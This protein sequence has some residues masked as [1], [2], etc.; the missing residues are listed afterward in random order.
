MSRKSVIL[1]VLLV[2]LAV[3]AAAGTAPAAPAPHQT[4]FVEAVV[5]WVKGLFPG[6]PAHGKIMPACGSGAN[7]DGTC[8]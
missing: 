2:A 8:I 6:H 4:S 5:Q 1:A 3:P 7:P